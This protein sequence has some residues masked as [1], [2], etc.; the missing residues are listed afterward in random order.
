MPN[1]ETL[2]RDIQTAIDVRKKAELGYF[3]VEFTMYG[4]AYLENEQVKYKVSPN[5]DDIYR[6]IESANLRDIYPSNVIKHTEKMPVPS[7]MKELIAQDVKVKV[8]QKL[9]KQ[10]SKGYFELV[11]ELAKK[12][13][14][15][16]AASFLWQE[17]EKIEGIFEEEKLCQFEVL[18]EYC[19]KCKCITKTSYDELKI[20]L[21]DERKSMEDDMVSKDTFEKD[22]YAVGYEENGEYKYSVNAHNSVIY[23]IMHEKEI[24][25]TFILPMHTHTYWYNY[26]KHISDIKT[27][28]LMEVKDKYTIEYCKKIKELRNVASPISK[29]EYYDIL[30]DVK[31]KYGDEAEKTLLRYGYRWGIL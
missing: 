31:E 5:K 25:G 29:N 14:T 3:N 2:H 20:W 22:F 9:Q 15:N 30:I 6:F 21:A 16:V 8:A 7:G 27:E 26:T 10:Y 24:N 23:E 11:Y 12:A 13:I 4:C 1:I 17:V 19:Y 28:F 18:V